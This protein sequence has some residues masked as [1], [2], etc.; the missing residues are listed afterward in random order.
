M[1]VAAILA[2]LTCFA[3]TIYVILPQ[4]LLDLRQVLGYAALPFSRTNGKTVDFLAVAV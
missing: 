4:F 1:T 2:I 3:K